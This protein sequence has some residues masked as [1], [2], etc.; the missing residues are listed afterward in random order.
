MDP[1]NT[2]TES[3]SITE[4]IAEERLELSLRNIDK[5][6]FELVDKVKKPREQVLYVA[7]NWRRW[8]KTAMN[9]TLAVATIA[10]LYR[11]ARR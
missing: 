7:H 1:L 8:R 6:L 5:N 2:L 9:A 3:P 10:L 11:V 4:Q